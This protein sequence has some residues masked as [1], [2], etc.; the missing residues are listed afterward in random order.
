M[1]GHKQIE[2]R[3]LWRLALLGVGTW[4]ARAWGQ[5]VEVSLHADE[6]WFRK[7]TCDCTNASPSVLAR[8]LGRG[9]GRGRG[10]DFGRRRG[11]LGQRKGGRGGEHAFRTK[12]WRRSN[13]D[14]LR[15][16]GEA[17]LKSATMPA[18]S[19]PRTCTPSGQTFLT[20][21]VQSSEPTP[22]S[23]APLRCSRASPRQEC[24]CRRPP[25]TFPSRYRRCTRRSNESRKERRSGRL[26]SNKCARRSPLRRRAILR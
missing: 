14:A 20:A 1:S 26:R 24:S 9:L 3:P 12:I 5:E 21:V 15:G 4:A 18:H 2:V 25:R 13:G 7:T 10:R 22:Q 6:V 23:R 16:N 8:T 11:G 19:R 17:S